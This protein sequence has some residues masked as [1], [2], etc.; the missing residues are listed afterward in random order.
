MALDR[1]IA[2]RCFFFSRRANLHIIKGVFV[3]GTVQRDKV[4]K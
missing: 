3:T 2:K 4:A 1:L